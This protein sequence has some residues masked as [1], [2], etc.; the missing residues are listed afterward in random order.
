MA[1]LGGAHDL[2]WAVD[3]VTGRPLPPELVE[4]A[5]REELQ[6]MDSWGVWEVRPVAEA[7]ERT[8]KKA[9]RRALGGP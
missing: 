3:D 6:F 4:S 7:W 9:H 1:A 2:G 5:R 8:G